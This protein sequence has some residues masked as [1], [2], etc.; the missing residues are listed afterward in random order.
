MTR[1]RRALPRTIAPDKAVGGVMARLEE[2]RQ[3]RTTGQWLRDQRKR[4][5]LTQLQLAQQLAID[6]NTVARYERGDMPL[7]PW[8]P[9]L[10]AFL[11]DR[12]AEQQATS[13]AQ[14]VAAA[15]ADDPFPDYHTPDPEPDA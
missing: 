10:L 14:A 8:V 9:K 6:A 12:H 15:R 13:V 4:L 1:S 3:Q 11:L 2:L 7:P 5:G